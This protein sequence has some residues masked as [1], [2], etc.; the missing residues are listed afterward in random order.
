MSI[1]VKEVCVR[2]LMVSLGFQIT[3]KLVCVS[4]DIVVA[5]LIVAFS[6]LSV[7]ARGPHSPP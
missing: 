7:L 3:F 4:V 5:V 6:H 1:L 2:L